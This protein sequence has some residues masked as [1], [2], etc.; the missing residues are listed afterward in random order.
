[1]YEISPCVKPYFYWKKSGH[2]EYG[3]D[4]KKM[5]WTEIA[6]FLESFLA[7]IT[8]SMETISHYPWSRTHFSTNQ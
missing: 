2:S 7:S 3:N 4:A 1:M 8:F 6:M 5:V